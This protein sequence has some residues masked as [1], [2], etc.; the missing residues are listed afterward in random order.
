[1]NQLRMG[2]RLLATGF[3]M[4]N[5]EGRAIHIPGPVVVELKADTSNLTTAYFIEK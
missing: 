2:N 5:I 4:I 1:M 3:I